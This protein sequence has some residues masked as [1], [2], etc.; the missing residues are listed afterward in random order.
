VKTTCAT[1]SLKE[2]APRHIV[3]CAGEL[4][5]CPIHNVYVRPDES[6]CEHYDETETA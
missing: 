2:S 3:R 5:Y 6:A 1:C 4:Y